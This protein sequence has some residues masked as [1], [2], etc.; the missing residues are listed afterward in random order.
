MLPEFSITR[1]KKIEKYSF[2]LL[3]EKLDQERRILR[4]FYNATVWNLYLIKFAIS[5]RCFFPLISIFANHLNHVLSKFIY[6]LYFLFIL[7]I[8]LDSYKNM[9][10]ISI[11]EG[12]FS[13]QNY[14]YYLKGFDISKITRLNHQNFAFKWQVFERRQNFSMIDY[15][16]K[17]LFVW[18]GNFLFRTLNPKHLTVEREKVEGWW[19][20]INP[21]CPSETFHIIFIFTYIYILYVYKTSYMYIHT[22]NI[23]GHTLYIKH[24]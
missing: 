7:Y 2:R 3:S 16:V 21:W 17:V 1:L 13:V 4:K 18:A 5:K 20:S 15:W 19:S 10:T 23:R 8:H 24:E 14:I 11:E 12:R 22:Y 9:Y 6:T